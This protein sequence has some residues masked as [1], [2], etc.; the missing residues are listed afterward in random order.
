MGQK[1]DNAIGVILDPVRFKET[2]LNISSLSFYMI[3][4][5]IHSFQVVTIKFCYPLLVYKLDGIVEI[6]LPYGCGALPWLS[7]QNKSH[8][9]GFVRIRRVWQ[10]ILKRGRYLVLRIGR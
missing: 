1:G 10:L 3:S 6:V 9:F 7:N 4:E 5:V 8:F 2:W